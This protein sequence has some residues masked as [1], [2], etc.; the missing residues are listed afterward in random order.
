MVPEGE[1]GQAPKSC[2]NHSCFNELSLK[3]DLKVRDT[4]EEPPAQG[5]PRAPCA[6]CM[7]MGEF[8]TSGHTL[9]P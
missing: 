3:L 8:L 5:S 9:S 7:G 6:F 2:K 1:T 4:P